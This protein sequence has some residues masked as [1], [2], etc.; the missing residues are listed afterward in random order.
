M[1]KFFIYKLTSPNGKVYIGQT[2]N[3]LSRFVYYENIKKTNS[4]KYL[5]NSI[6]KY[7]FHEFKKE[8]LSCGLGIPFLSSS[9]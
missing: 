2:Y 5:S 8:I 9:P 3:V 4:Q 6:L 1:R 7:G